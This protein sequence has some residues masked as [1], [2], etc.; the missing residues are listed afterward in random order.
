MTAVDTQMFATAGDV[1]GA[2]KHHLWG[3]IDGEIEL[4]D[5]LVYR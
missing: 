3:A 1:Y 5:C 2:L 4:K